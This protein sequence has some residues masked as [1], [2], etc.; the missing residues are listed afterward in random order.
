MCFIVNLLVR[1]EY[2]SVESYGV[3]VP[4]SI[5]FIILGGA[6]VVDGHIYSYGL[7]EE[8]VNYQA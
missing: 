1:V 8:F 2:R 3:A 4:S 5:F 7:W 6:G